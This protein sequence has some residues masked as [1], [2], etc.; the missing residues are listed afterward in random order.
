MGISDNGEMLT[1][2]L[3]NQE[4]P[5]IR[6]ILKSF[7]SI[8]HKLKF[9]ESIHRIYQYSDD[10]KIFQY[11]STL[12]YSEKDTDGNLN[13]SKR[14]GGLSFFSKEEAFLK[15]YCEAIER[16]TCS[17]YK[18]K[19]LIV[20][21]FKNLGKIALDPRT[22]TSFSTE[23]KQADN[24]ENFRFGINDKF[25]WIKGYSTNGNEKFIPAQLVYFNYRFL[26]FEK[27]IVIPISTGAAGGGCLAAAIERGILEIVERDSFMIY[28][29]NRLPG[30][31][32][33]ID[34]IKD[35]KF[36]S[37][38]NIFKRYS[39]ELHVIDLTTD[40]NIPSFASIIVDRSGVGPS[41]SVGLKASLNP[42][43]AI[44]GGINEAMHLRR[45][46]RQ[47]NE[48]ENDR[49][50]SL[51]LSH[52]KTV[53]ERGMYWYKLDML[54]H[55]SFWLDQR[56]TKKI[57]SIQ[58]FSTAG[59]RLRAVVSVFEKSKYDVFFV[60][61]TP[62]ELKSISYRVVKV[63]IPKLQP[64][65]LDEEYRYLGGARLFEVSAKLGF[66][67]KKESSLNN[68]PHPFL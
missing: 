68:I 21:S 49:Y 48:D 9:I 20:D 24:F 14:S 39:L 5:S 56:A 59:E 11:S 64:L 29:L 53:E 38:L 63:V 28:Y 4:E 52:I 31:K 3:F 19:G 46:I 47:V 13:T 1:K 50:Q 30:L 62:P 7:S 25:G 32:I 58:S 8:R 16:Y 44:I 12:S 23:Q 54:K 57:P 40:L 60:D 34:S 67:S 36:N 66:I 6:N 22:V 2:K 26:P 42:I 33:K 37:I 43:E 51:K 18:R 15:C 27:R 35:K 61:L 45:W 65:Y 55:L 41:I 10:P 17:V